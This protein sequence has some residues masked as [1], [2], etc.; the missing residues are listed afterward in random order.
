MKRRRSGFL[1]V[2]N[3]LGETREVEK[4]YADGSYNCPFCFGAVTPAMVARSGGCENPARIANKS[5]SVEWAR[6]QVE[7][8]TARRD[9]EARR[10]R[11]LEW[12]RRYR[13]EQAD[14]ERARRRELEAQALARGAC[15][16][17]LFKDYG[18]Q[19][20]RPK[21]VKHRGLCPKA[22]R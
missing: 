5:V 15:T 22:P 12:G 16:R 11:D 9:E 6:R 7:A 14:N 13:E 18:W 17:C 21:F 4:V 8:A 1:A 10:Q 20:G 2:T 19:V 3:V